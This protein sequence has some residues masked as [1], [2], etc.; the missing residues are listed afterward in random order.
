LDLFDAYCILF[1]YST[2]LNYLQII[3]ILYIE[4]RVTENVYVPYTSLPK[5]KNNI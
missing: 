3:R 2:Q 1:E 4:L 5:V